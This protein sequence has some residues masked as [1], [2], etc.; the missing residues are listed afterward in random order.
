MLT[1]SQN[2]SSNTSDLLDVMHHPR[3]TVVPEELQ[4]SSAGRG[5]TVH[6]KGTSV[7]WTSTLFLALV[8]NCSRFFI[9]IS[10]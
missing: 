3:N 4:Q 10:P 8:A 6:L 1:E 7:A 5:G 9:R 2:A